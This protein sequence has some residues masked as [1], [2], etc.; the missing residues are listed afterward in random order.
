VEYLQWWLKPG[1]VPT[2]LTTGSINDPAPGALDQRGTQTVIGGETNRQS[3][4]GFRITGTYVLDCCGL[5]S[6]DASGFLL[7]NQAT[8]FRASSDGSVVLARPFFNA[9]TGAEDA[10]P[11]ALP[12]TQSGSF[13]AD[14]L[15][16]LMGGEVNLRLHQ[17]TTGPGGVHFALLGGGRFLGMDDRLVLGDTVTELPAG[18]PPSQNF[19]F[20]DNFT[21]YNR[22]Y[23]GQVGLEVLLSAVHMT[24]DAQAKLAL[25]DT[26]QTVKTSGFTQITDATGAVIGL[27]RDRALLVQPSNFGSA[28]RDRFSFVPEVTFNWAINFNRNAQLFVGYNLFYWTHVARAG[29]QIDR[30]VSVQPVP[31]PGGPN[32]PQLGPARPAFAFQD[33]SFWAQGVNLG[34]EFRW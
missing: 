25:G 21:T 7:G 20:S 29:D 33:G 30:V 13:S 32:P 28:S 24:L 31:T 15:T 3:G 16:R 10:D 27:A 5:L 2:L 6:V 4:P 12:G 19:V 18:Q 26:T 8:H 34:V 22:F 9:A 14:A 17:Q 23:G 11:V 1:N